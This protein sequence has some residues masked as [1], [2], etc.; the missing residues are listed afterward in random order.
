M[1]DNE[2]FYTKSIFIFRRDLRLI[3]NIGLL[4]ACEN[5]DMV[6]PIF[7][8]T[9]EQLKN[10]KFKSDNAVQFMMESL[11]NLDSDLKKRGSRLFYFYGTP[12]DVISKLLSKD[13]DI[14]A[15]FVNM[16]Y[17][18]YSVKRDRAIERMCKDHD[19]A[20]KS[21]E[22]VLLNPVGSIK[23]K[24]GTI[25]TK[26]T[27]YFNAAKKKD[28][29]DPSGSRPKNFISKRSKI[30]GEYTADIHK[31][32]TQI[33]EDIAVNGGRNTAQK[34]LNEIG[35]FKKYNAERNTLNIETT[36]LS[37]YIKFGCVS[38]R[39]VYKAF[40]NKLGS[41]ND[42]VKQL[43]WRDFY[44]NIA[45]EYPHTFKSKGAL[46]DK[47]NEIKWVNNR[48][49]FKKWR[50]AKTGFPVVDA[51][52]RELNATGFMHNRGR[53]ITSAFLVKLLLIDW[54]WGEMYY[55]TK[56]VDY[57]PS[58]NLGNW[59]WT[60]GVGADSQ[61]YFRIFNPW[62]QSEKHDAD[63]EYIKKWIPELKDVENKHIHNW[64]EWYEEYPEI[65]YPKPIIDYSK[66]R[67][68]ALKMYKKVFK[69]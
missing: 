38:I 44:Y 68:K 62:S 60:A 54:N 22:D 65:N 10:N 52:M 59:S 37:A 46:K 24:G 18:P 35:K 32:Y 53:L 66:Q 51:C 48:N 26:F 33:N 45:Y 50:E 13:K 21:Y 41:R 1:A 17:T 42:L 67:D 34:I 3:D 56:L 4:A 29:D 57:D 9:P 31:F 55:A 16:D 11:D 7:I 36:R 14:G 63:C 61:P 40:K 49:W 6:I 43:Y 27:P 64:D 30:V 47:Y 2:E 19:V 58:V 25:Y 28:V 8:F 12:D 23:T 20:F 69:N 5:S 15:V 39:E